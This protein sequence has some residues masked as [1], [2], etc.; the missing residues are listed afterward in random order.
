MMDQLCIGLSLNHRQKAPATMEKV[1][2]TQIELAQQAEQAKLDFV[3]KPDALFAHPARMSLATGL[4]PTILLSLIAQQTTHIGLV[5]TISASFMPPYILARQLQTLHWISQGRAGWNIVT[6]LDGADNFGESATIPSE[7]R[8]EKAAECTDV[9]QRLW[10]SFP[11]KADVTATTKKLVLQPIDHHGNHFDVKGPL[12]ISMHSSGEPVLFQ[13]GASEAGRQFASS[14]AS[15]IFA[16]T[17]S[18]DTAIELRQDLRRRAV[19]HN[20]SPSDIRVLPGLYFF[21]GDSEEEA[22]LMHQKAHQH[23]SMEH[24]YASIETTIGL[25]LRGLSLNERITKDMMPDENHM[26]RSR[27]HADLLR[28][29]ISE[30]EP[31]IE[32]LLTRPEVVDSAHWVEV[33]TAK[34]V[35]GQITHWFNNGAID[36][37][38]AIP[39]GAAKSLQL[40]FNQVIPLLRGAG[41]FRDEYTG[42]TLRDHLVISAD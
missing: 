23:L 29:F 1:I 14:A 39:G 16:A 35:A 31:T 2:S 34:Q 13:A 11:D 25:D 8:Y 17:P 5:T 40:F 9:V 38:I 32:D 6:S 42:K 37:F 27:T 4:D 26:V 12:N 3:F 41:L 20:R 18:M 10:R 7:V 24:R 30:N 33:G 22:Q 19:L 21:I 36:G 15:A 28:R